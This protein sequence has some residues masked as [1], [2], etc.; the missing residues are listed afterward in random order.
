MGYQRADK[1]VQI[2][3]LPKMLSCL[4]DRPAAHQNMYDIFS[5]VTFLNFIMLTCPTS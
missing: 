5:K 4:Q 2:K 1:D 3:L